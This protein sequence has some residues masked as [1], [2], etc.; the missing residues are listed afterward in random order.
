MFQTFDSQGDP[1]VGKERVGRLREWLVA[2][3]VDGFLVP[4]ADE[5]QGEY[6]ALGSERLRWLT[7]FSGSAGVA[8]VLRDRAHIFVDGRYTLQVRD[9][10]D[11]TIFAIESLV[12]TPPP[13]WIGKNLGKGARIG[14]DPWLH[15]IS[16]AEALGKAAA[17]V[18]AELV[19]LAKNPI[20]ELWSDRPAP[21]LGKVEIQPLAYA[22]ELARDKLA[23]LAAKLAEEGVAHT[24]LTDPAS[25][26][27]TFNI[28]GSDVPHT[29]LPLCF[30]ILSAEGPHLLFI[31]ERKLRI[32][33]KAYLTQLCDLR[34]LA[35]LDAELA[36][37]SAGG[38]KI[39]LD[40]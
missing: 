13:D 37:L 5:H 26:A 14:F 9:Q 10:V 2:H 30:A 19:P 24:V 36:R 32:E 6:V 4:R 31:D 35:D 40:P 38:R 28:R 25:V 22:G 7:G 12:E 34:A 8:L 3:D 18:G 1:S 33:P 29:P 17:K 20:D 15:P 23:R 21:P 11:P 39:G 27:W 16:D